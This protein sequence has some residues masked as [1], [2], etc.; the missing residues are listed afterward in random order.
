MDAQPIPGLYGCERLSPDQ[1]TL[2]G[3]AAAQRHC[4]HGFAL[5]ETALAVSQLQC[6]RKPTAD[7]VAW[8][9]EITLPISFLLHGYGL[10]NR[11]DVMTPARQ[12]RKRRQERPTAEHAEYAENRL[13]HGSPSAYSVYSAVH[14]F[15]EDSPP[16][17]QNFHYCGAETGQIPSPGA[18]SLNDNL[19]GCPRPC[20]LLC[21]HRGS[22]V[23]LAACRT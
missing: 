21:G 5:G 22:A 6:S 14:R 13:P 16:P 18:L 12:S 7:Y 2:V 8:V 23:P 4:G 1:P 11:A 17:A 19:V 15:P 10:V 9:C 20:F 3:T